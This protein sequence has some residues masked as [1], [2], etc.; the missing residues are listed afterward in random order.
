MHETS[1]FFYS[2]INFVHS[3][4]VDVIFTLSFY[5][6]HMLALQLWRHV[7]TYVCLAGLITVRVYIITTIGYD[8]PVSMMWNIGIKK[9][10]LSKQTG[11]CIVMSYPYMPPMI[12]TV[13]F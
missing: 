12:R 13:I 1:D 9:L 11:I 3:H 8:I 4:T 6:L 10:I 5:T 2:I 7:M